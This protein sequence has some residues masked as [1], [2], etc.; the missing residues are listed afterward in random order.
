M[1]EHVKL[2]QIGRKV[3]NPK[4]KVRIIFE[5]DDNN[6]KEFF[7]QTLKLTRI[8]YKKY[9]IPIFCIIRCLKTSKMSRLLL[10]KATLSTKILII[11]SQRMCKKMAKYVHI[12]A[13]VSAHADTYQIIP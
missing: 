7:A 4:A 2:R 10:Q 5:L 8:N 12:Y 13:Q 1:K 6:L 11:P 9:N 3:N